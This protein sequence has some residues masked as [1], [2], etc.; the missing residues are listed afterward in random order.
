M[1][2]NRSPY[3][4]GD[5][6]MSITGNKLYLSEIHTSG[7]HKCLVIE[8]NKAVDS[9]YGIASQLLPYNHSTAASLRKACKQIEEAEKAIKE[10]YQHRDAIFNYEKERNERIS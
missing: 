3:K 2:T 7:I 5:I 4:R 8:A 1:I 6:L 10:L 9:W